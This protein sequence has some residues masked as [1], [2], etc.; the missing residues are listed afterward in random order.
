MVPGR[1]SSKVPALNVLGLLLAAVFIALNGFFVAAEFAFVKVSTT[2]AGTEKTRGEDPRIARAR[3]IVSRIDRYLS[4]TQ[5]GIT[6]ASLGLGW[7]GERALEGLVHDAF[8]LV[9]G[10]EPGSIARALA[11]ALAFTL[12]T[13]SHV[14]FGELVPKLVA[15]QRSEKLAYASAAP[16]Q[17]IYVVFRPLLFILERATRV[18][19]RAMGMSADAASEGTLS[20]E[21]LVGILAANAA[22]SP[23]GKA[24]AEL[25]ERVLRFSQRTARHAM[26]PRVDMF[27]IQI[28]TAGEEAVRQIRTHQYSRVILTRDHS[29][30]EIAGYLYA[31]DF[32]VDPAASKLKDLTSVRRDILFVPETQSLLDVL[33][34]MQL[35]QIPI[36]V[37]V[38]E[39]GGTSGIVTMEDLLEEIVGE[40]RDELDVEVARVVPVANAENAWDVDAR[41]TLEELRSIGVKVDESESAET[42]GTVVLARLGRIP[43]IG[44]KV[45]L[46]DDVTAEVTSVSRRRIMRVRVRIARAAS[47]SIP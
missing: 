11:I 2:L 9:L 36:A 14:L 35:A 47:D 23:S 40:I 31:K 15:M 45:A 16:L 34:N 3:L 6:L 41:A 17:L 4:V 21:E 5:F 24:K 19:L 25:V 28:A 7:I 12:L 37:V 39:Y 32:L 46:A 13:F 26:V 1:K 22:R 29:V 30:D 20:E 43:R 18:I 44:D 10:R 8:I 42:V 33:R 38:D 27:T